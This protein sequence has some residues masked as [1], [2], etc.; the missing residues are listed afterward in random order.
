MK[1]NMI[2]FRSTLYVIFLIF[3]FILT[4]CSSTESEEQEK[5]GRK[6]NLVLIEIQ[7]SNPL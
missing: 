2:I 4:G 5:C 3:L 1:F 7:F 6:M